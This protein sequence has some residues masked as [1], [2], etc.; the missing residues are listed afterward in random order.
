MT[1]AHATLDL[2]PAVPADA[3][4][5]FRLTEACMRRY[6][7]QT[8]G[9]WNEALTR[10]S[11]VPRTHQIIRYGGGDIGCIELIESSDEF[12]L[13]KLYILP[14][15]QNRGIG[16]RLMSEFIA[17]ARGKQKPIRLSVLAVNPARRF[18]ERLGFHLTRSTPE[19]NYLEWISDQQ[20]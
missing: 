16:T 4:F 11:F 17:V 2:R 9:Q 7:E 14:D 8:W 5:V 19:R 6:A 10:D 18:Y 3:E 13:N 20:R 12:D 15:Y 1:E